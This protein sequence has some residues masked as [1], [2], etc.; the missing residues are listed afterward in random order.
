MR[1]LFSD[2]DMPRLN[3]YP[4]GPCHNRGDTQCCNAKVVVLPDG[5]LPQTQCSPTRSCLICDVIH[6]KYATTPVISQAA[7]HAT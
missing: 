6:G 2:T 7:L 3:C 1:R 4:W 5:S